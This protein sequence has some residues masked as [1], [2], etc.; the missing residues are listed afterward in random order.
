MIVRPSC[1]S[2]KPALDIDAIPAGLKARP[3]WVVWKYVKRGGKTTKPPVNPQTGKPTDAT[4]R[5]AWMP[6]EAALEAARRFEGIGFAVEGSGFTGIDLDNCIGQDGEIAEREAAIVQRFRSY[7][8]RTPSGRGLRIWI[9]GNLPP[10][11][12]R[13]GNIEVYDSGRYFTVT[14]QHVEGTPATVE[15]RQ[16]ELAEF[17][18]ETFA[19]PAPKPKPAPQTVKLDLSEIIDRALRS[20]D[21][22]FRD[23]WNGSNLGKSP[24][25]GDLALCGKLLFWLGG[26]EAQVDAAFRMSPRFREKWDERRGAQT[27]GQRT[28]AKAMSGWD[29]ECYTP[30]PKRGAKGKARPSSNGHP[31][32]TADRAEEHHASNGKRSEFPLTDLGNAERMIAKH[33]RNVRFCHPWKK[34]LVWDGKRWSQDSTA[35]VNRLAKKAVRSMLVEAGNIDDDLRRKQL[36]EWEQ[37]SEKRERMQAMVALAS[38]EEGVP[39]LPDEMDA[40]PWAFNCKNGTVDLRTGKLREHRREDRFTKL[41]PV[42]FDPSAECPL[43]HSTLELFFQKDAD[44][45]GY[46]QRICGYAMTGVIRD[47][48]MPVCYGTGANGKSTMLGTL[49]DLFGRDYA[50]KAPPG[51]LMAKKHEAHPTEQADLFGK[52]LVVAI[53][54]EGGRRLNE[55]LVKELTGGDRI[56]ARRMREDFWEFSPAHTLIMATNHRPVIR[57]TDNGIWRRL[58]LVPFN[59]KVEGSQADLS[60]PAKLR[61]EFPGILA[62]CV[63]GC[64]E[65][66]AKGLEEPDAVTAATSEYRDEQDVLGGFIEDRCIVNRSARVKASALYAAYKQWSMD[67]SEFTMTQTAFGTAIQERGIT[68]ERSNGIWYNGLGLVASPER[69]TAGDFDATSTMAGGSDSRERGEL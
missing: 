19:E 68:K 32:P 40:D 48:L 14:G 66:Q 42:P 30:K 26:D 5:T 7:T 52:R 24:S 51:L 6:F 59:T 2:G 3:Q 43:W 28:L 67:G 64:L 25:E 10:G 62:W 53:E 39:I 45:I 49:L 22:R 65:W 8:E 29:G 18:A 34:W 36:A 15:E 27:Y 16:G 4:D 33:G 1:P 41:C 9:N 38:A 11:G 55:T 57:G 46:F 54:S 20:G 47:H 56:R 63:R 12:R 17:H 21:Q 44:L 23:L 37:T 69:E 13:K 50:M 35:K 58:R 60:M 61:A 31:K